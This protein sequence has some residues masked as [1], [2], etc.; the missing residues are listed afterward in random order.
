MRIE[1][2][3]GDGRIPE[4]AIDELRHHRG[5]ESLPETVTVGQEVR[6]VQPLEQHRQVRLPQW[7]EL[8]LHLS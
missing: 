4:Q 6:P 3:L 1:P 2:N 7:P 8:E 5:A